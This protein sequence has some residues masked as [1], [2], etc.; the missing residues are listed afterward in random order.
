MDDFILSFGTVK[1]ENFKSLQD[2]GAVVQ[3]SVKR[4]VPVTVRRGDLIQYL[5]LTPKEWS[6]KGLLGCNIVQI[7]HIER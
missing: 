6:G 4:N 3:H 1:Y 2:I 7:E 5:V